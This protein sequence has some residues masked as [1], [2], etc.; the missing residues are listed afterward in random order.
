MAAYNLHQQG[1]KA[2]NVNVEAEVGVREDKGSQSLHFTVDH[3]NFLPCVT[4]SRSMSVLEPVVPLNSESKLDAK[5]WLW[6]DK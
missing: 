1:E 2:V 5:A 3:N 6:L 4:V